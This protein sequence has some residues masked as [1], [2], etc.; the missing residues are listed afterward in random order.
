MADL[1]ITGLA[2]DIIAFG[3]IT[4]ILVIFLLGLFV[5]WQWI[6]VDLIAKAVLS[7]KV[8]HRLMTF[9]WYYNR[10]LKEQIDLLDKKDEDA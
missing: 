6:C 10:G 4:T 5:V 8:W 3:T 1:K 9:A 7:A 2:G